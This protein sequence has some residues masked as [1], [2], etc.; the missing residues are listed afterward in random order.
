MLLKVIAT[1]RQAKVDEKQT[2][3][4]IG[5]VTC[6]VRE[7]DAWEGG[8]G[9]EVRQQYF[10]CTSIEPEHRIRDDRWT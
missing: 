5:G 4:T 1:G 10:R 9:G 2:R 7:F 3:T 6:V 8:D